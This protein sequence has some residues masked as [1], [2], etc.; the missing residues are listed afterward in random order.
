MSPFPLSEHER[1]A[2]AG[3]RGVAGLMLPESE[4][5]AP[6]SSTGVLRANGDWF[7]PDVRARSVIYLGWSRSIRPRRLY[8]AMR[9]GIGFVVALG[10]GGRWQR[11]LI[12]SWYASYLR[13]RIGQYRVNSRLPSSSSRSPGREARWRERLAGVVG[14]LCRQSDECGGN[15]K[16]LLVTGALGAGGAERQVLNT[17]LA[18]S[19]SGV[20]VEVLSIYTGK[21]EFDFYR[22]RIEEHVRVRTLVDVS[23]DLFRGRAAS[24]EDLLER[25]EGKTGMVFTGLFPAPFVEQTLALAAALLVIK[26][27]VVHLWQDYTNLVGGLAALLAGVP[28]VVLGG[29]SVAPYHFPYHQR[30]MRSVYQVLLAY[31]QV[32]LANNSA[33]GAADYERWLGLQPGS[34]VVVHNGIDTDAFLAATTPTQSLRAIWGIPEE[35]PLVGGVF[36]FGPEKDPLLWLASA[37]EV[38]RRFPDAYFVLVGTGPMEGAMREVIRKL[39]LSARVVMPGLMDTVH[40]AFLAMD[41]VL[42]ASENEGLPNVLIEAQLLGCP[43]VTTAVGGCAETVSQGKTGW[44]V[45]N[46]SAECLAERVCFILQNDEWRAN[47]QCLGPVH[48]HETFGLERMLDSTLRLYG[49]TAADRDV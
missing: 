38:L 44:T 49:W 7:Y 15:D 39:G 42:L 1:R 36:R 34:V 40:Q 48:I 6:D 17:A 29:R 14:G 26:P 30:Y 18:L 28:R 11:R 2:L 4:G 21:E 22:G 3:L 47:A 31:P 10:F 8:E 9:H 5:N 46:R 23:A 37:S 12:P 33:A 27:N 13:A 19:G 25:L 43:V 32:C 41:V 35:A 45:A 16:V 24:F 20:E